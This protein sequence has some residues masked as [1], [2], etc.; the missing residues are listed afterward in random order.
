[1]TPCGIPHHPKNNV[2]FSLAKKTF[3]HN[4]LIDEK[5]RKKANPHVNKNQSKYSTHSNSNNTCCSSNDSGYLK[6]N[7][8]NIL[9]NQ[10][11]HLLFF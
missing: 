2:Y 9:K 10:K 11:L 1:M 8:S 7:L 5:K 4:K 3:P 6:F